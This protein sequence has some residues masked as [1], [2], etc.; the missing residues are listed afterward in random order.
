MDLYANT[1]SFERCCKAVEDFSHPPPA[2]SPEEKANSSKGELAAAG[3][4][5]L[6]RALAG[7]I[8]PGAIGGC[9][10]YCKAVG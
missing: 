8:P 5:S 4:K 2:P 10:R 9:R 1:V 7:N 6:L 3:V